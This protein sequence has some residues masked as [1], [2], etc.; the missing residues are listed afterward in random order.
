MLGS[1]AMSG[2]VA[3][4]HV[5]DPNES[6]Q[7]LRT[8][9]FTLSISCPQIIGT[10]SKRWVVVPTASSS[11][12]NDHVIPVPIQIHPALQSWSKAISSLL[13]SNSV[14]LAGTERR[15]GFCRRIA[16]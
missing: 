1:V 12:P 5:W 14:T 10:K 15:M 6:A 13:R 7:R 16:H 4:L 2:I 9:Q 11:C 3:L 8:W